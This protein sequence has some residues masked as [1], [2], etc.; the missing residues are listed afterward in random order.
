[1]S[2][3][4]LARVGRCQLAPSGAVI[5][6]CPRFGGLSAPCCCGA[7]GLVSGDS[8]VDI[9][10]SPCAVTFGYCEPADFLP[11]SRSSASTVFVRSVLLLLEAFVHR[12]DRR[13]H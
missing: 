6:V 11:L 2:T 9:S 4:T 1:M 12:R 7:T 13:C 3:G 5:G 10:V 8:P